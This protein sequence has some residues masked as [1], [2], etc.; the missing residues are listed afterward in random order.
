[1]NDSRPKMDQ[2]KDQ[3]TPRP[4]LDPTP[5]AVPA[6]P[7]VAGQQPKRPDTGGNSPRVADPKGPA[8]L[9]TQGK[10]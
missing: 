10:R 9:V 6:K 4:V 3:T 5:N 7:V 8:P 2:P 1:M